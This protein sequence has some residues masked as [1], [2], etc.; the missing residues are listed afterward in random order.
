[1]SPFAHAPRPTTVAAA[2]GFDVPGVRS[3][4]MFGSCLS[5]LTKSPT[6]IPDWFAVVDDVG[7]A[8]RAL[9]YGPLARAMARLLPP[10]V[11]VPKLNLVT[12]EQLAEQLFARNDLYFGGRLGKKTELVYA[13]DAVCAA[14]WDA[15]TATAR[16]T[17]AEL[18]LCAQPREVPLETVLR[19]CIS[20]SYDAEVRPERPEKVRALFDAFAPWYREQ[21]TPLLKHRAQ[22]GLVIDDRPDDVRAAEARALGRLLFRS[23]VRSVA[24]WPKNLVLYRGAVTY[25]LQKLKRARRLPHDLDVERRRLK[26]AVE[27]HPQR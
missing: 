6:S 24:R 12:S 15:A 25:V 18:A 17:M 11:V 2:L 7:E 19:R 20:L 5:P 14:Q 16:A 21:Y 9:G 1:M 26:G 23:R 4:A 22:G 13:R 10:A 27:P 3:L 8:L